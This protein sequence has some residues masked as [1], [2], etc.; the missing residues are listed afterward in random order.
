MK[1]A[2]FKCTAP[3]KLDTY[4]GAFL[5]VKETSMIMSLGFDA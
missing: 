2:A 1:R 3:K 4:L 5:C